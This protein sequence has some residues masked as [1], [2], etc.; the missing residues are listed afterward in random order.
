MQIDPFVLS[1]LTFR[2]SSKLQ[3]GSKLAHAVLNPIHVTLL[4]DE[5]SNPWQLLLHQDVLIRHRGANHFHRY[6][7]SRNISLLSLAYLL[8]VAR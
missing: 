6:E 1:S 5:Q 2:F 3:I 4:F 8:F 7:L